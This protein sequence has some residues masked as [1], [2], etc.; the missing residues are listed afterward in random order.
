[1]KNLFIL[2]LIIIIL[3]LTKP[4]SAIADERVKEASAK[5]ALS[6]DL[7]V[8]DMRVKILKSYLEDNNSPLAGDAQAFVENADKYDLDWRLVAAI[9]GN[10]SGFGLHIPTASYNAWGW[11]VYGTNVHYFTSWED[12]I[13][14]VSKN[15]RERYMDK[16]GAQ[17]VYE[18]GSFYASSP[19]WA[20]N[21]TLYMNRIENYALANPKDTLSLSL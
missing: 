6:Y 12:G 7:P 11:G 17:N 18:I 5:I 21:V 20:G 2:I 10:E 4:N 19:R 9:A 8:E 1:M 15:L 16:W 3:S 14:T 13:E